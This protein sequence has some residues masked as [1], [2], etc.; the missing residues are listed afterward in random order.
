ML[1]PP[2]STVINETQVDTTRS[3]PHLLD[4]ILFH[5]CVCV[6]LVCDK[7]KASSG[8]R[9]LFPL[10][11]TASSSLSSF[12][13]KKKKTLVFVK[14]TNQERVKNHMTRLL[15]TTGNPVET[16]F[17]LPGRRSAVCLDWITHPGMSRTS[18]PRR[19]GIDHHVFFSFFKN[20]KKVREADLCV[21]KA[22]VSSSQSPGKHHARQ[23]V[24]QKCMR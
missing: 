20:K 5:P 9:L 1:G 19:G 22:S 4:A 24:D 7:Q 11:W 16:S 17:R 23:V 8:P 10:C 3:L 18:P 15:Q 14:E 13:K 6:C 2:V 21:V 12:F